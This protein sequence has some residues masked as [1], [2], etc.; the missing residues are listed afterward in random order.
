[1]PIGAARST[2]RRSEPGKCVRFISQLLSRF[3]VLV[4]CLHLSQYGSS[5]FVETWGKRTNE[6]EIY[7][8]RQFFHIIYS[9]Q[10]VGDL[11]LIIATF[12][13]A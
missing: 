4:F 9:C 7:L 13:S 2:E 12:L 3:E 10:D 11:D 1:M 5:K 8:N 6:R